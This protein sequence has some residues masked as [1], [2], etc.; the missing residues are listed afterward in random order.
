MGYIYK[1]T[2]N[3]TKKIYIG[4]SQST[5]QERWKE[6]CR[7]A[8]L[9]S[10]G[11]YNFPFHRAIRKYGP[12]DFIIEIIDETSD[13]ELLKEKEKEWIAYYNSYYEGYNS[14]LGGDGNCR[15]NYDDICDFYL[16]NGNSLKLT[17]QHFKIYDQ[18][19]YKALKSKNIDY[20][21]LQPT[22][23]KEY[24]KDKKIIYC[25][26]LNKK[27]NTMKEIDEFFGKSAHPNVRRA[28]NG[29]TKKAYGYTWKE[30]DIKDDI[31]NK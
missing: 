31:C 6:H 17:C 29:V 30:I 27:F 14:T 1:I 3:T 23:K 10:H 9:P 7:T 11:D 22:I 13:S 8:F 15:Y 25:V 28:L 20:K 18:V 12:E 19:V 2:C 26:E 16:Q 21:N 5:V 24:Y 4:K